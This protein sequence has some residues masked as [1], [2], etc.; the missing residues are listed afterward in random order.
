MRVFATAAV[1]VPVAAVAD[2]AV[3]AV[4][5]AAGAQ[6]AGVARPLDS[7]RALARAASSGHAIP[8]PGAT[9]ATQT[10]TANPDGT[11]TLHQSIAPVRK[12]VGGVW[13]ALDATLKRESDGSVSPATTTSALTLSGGGRGPLATMSTLGTSL[14]V[15]LP[16]PLPA[17]V[18]SG[19]TATYRNVL[20]GVDVQV[21]A[22]V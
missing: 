9:T 19:R 16:V 11:L 17:P 10:L 22:N 4:V 5:A 6:S 21:R 15:W 7:A 20:P 13:E 18:L 12:R 8:V 14:S 2:P 3:H 1:L